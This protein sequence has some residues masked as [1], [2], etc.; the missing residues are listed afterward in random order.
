METSLHG[1]PYCYCFLAPNSSPLSLLQLEAPVP[2]QPFLYSWH[3]DRALGAVVFYCFCSKPKFPSCLRA[4]AVTY[5]ILTLTLDTQN[6]F[7]LYVC[8]GGAQMRVHVCKGGYS[9]LPAQQALYPPKH[10]PSPTA[11][12]AYIVFKIFRYF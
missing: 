4:S 8:V 6:D 11:P 2:S 7:F 10:L 9:F 1:A 5:S 12:T 3:R